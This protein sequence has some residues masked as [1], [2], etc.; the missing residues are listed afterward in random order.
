MSW[1][2]LSTVNLH[3][4]PTELRKQVLAVFHKRNQA[5]IFYTT[6]ALLL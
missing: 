5:F 3:F 4:D 2:K 1:K 6:S